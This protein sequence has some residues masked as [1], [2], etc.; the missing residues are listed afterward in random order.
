PRDRRRWGRGVL[1]AASAAGVLLLGGVIYQ[2]VSSG[3]SHSGASDSSVRKSVAGGSDA[4]EAQVRQLLAGKSSGA[5]NT[6]LVG[7]PDFTANGG[8]HTDIAPNRAPAAVPPCVLKATQRSTPP[9]AAQREVFQGKDA[10]LLVLP[11]PKDSGKVDA[12]VVS[13]SCTASS[14]GAVLFQSAYPR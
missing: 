13:A 10:Y 5:A 12:Y 7:G 3:G 2:T 8:N 4:V 1:A 6:P 14:P 9:L 11:D